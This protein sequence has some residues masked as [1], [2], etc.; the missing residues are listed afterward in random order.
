MEGR[1]RI[2]CTVCSCKFND[3]LSNE[4]ELNTINVTPTLNNNTKKP[5]ESKCSSYKCEC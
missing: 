4:C 1:Q 2:N 3:E 5:E